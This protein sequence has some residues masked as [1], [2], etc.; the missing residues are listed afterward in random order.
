MWCM[1]GRTKM[2]ELKL[3]KQHMNEIWTIKVAMKITNVK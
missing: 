2:N 3:F 1:A